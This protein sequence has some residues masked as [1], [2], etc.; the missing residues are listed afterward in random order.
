MARVIMNGE[1]LASCYRHGAQESANLREPVRSVQRFYLAIS[2]LA[3]C[4]RSGA[5]KSS[6]NVSPRGHG[7]LAASLSVSS[8]LTLSL[9]PQLPTCKA[10]PRVGLEGGALRSSYSIFRRQAGDALRAFPPLQHQ[11][12]AHWSLW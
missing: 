5:E 1:V 10:Q 11:C 9:S 7:E 8:P 4:K 6:H 3:A 12:S 2:G